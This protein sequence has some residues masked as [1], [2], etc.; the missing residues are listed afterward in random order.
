[1]RIGRRAAALA[2]LLAMAGTATAGAQ[3]PNHEVEHVKVASFD[4]TTLDGWIVRPADVPA[5]AR[6]PVVLW[7]APYFG[8][9]NFYPFPATL[10]YPKCTYA[11]G[12]NPELYDN[13][14]VSEAVPV[15][16][17]LEHG[18][19]VAIFNVRGTGN[20]GGCFDWFGAREQRDQ[21]ELVEWLGTRPWSNGNVGMMGLSYHGTT[22]WE[23]AIQNPP[24]LRTIVPA[25]IVSD[26][27]LFSH[28]PQGATFAT[29]GLFEGNFA[30]RVSLTPP[31]HGPAEHFTVDH[32]PVR[33]ERLCPEVAK[34]VAEDTAGTHTDLRDAAFWAERRLIDRF[35]EIEA[36]VFLV[37]GFQDHYLSGHQVQANEVWHTLR[38]PKRMLVGQWGHSF[39]EFG[40]YNPR[41]VVDDWHDRLLEWL[42][43]WLKDG[44]GPAPGEGVVEYQEGLYEDQASP[45]ASTIDAPAPPWH[46]SSAWPPAEARE[47][48]LHLAEGRLTGDPRAGDGS[49]EASPQIGALGSP[50]QLLCPEQGPR[51]GPTSVT[52]LSEPVRE[53]VRIAGNPFAHLRITSD[54]PGGLVAVHV[55]DV[56]PD[57]V[58]VADDG[59]AHGVRYWSAGTADLRFHAG[60][61]TGRDFPVGTPTTLRVDLTDL[62]ETLQPGH[63]LAVVV[64]RGDVLDR[65]GQPL[66]PQVRVHAGADAEASHVVLPVVCGTLGG[67]APVVDHPRRPFLPPSARS[68]AG[69]GAQGPPVAC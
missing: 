41:W 29:I 35:D 7:S 54:L 61:M 14:S 58:C 23:A 44:E 52:Y 68:R 62:A 6:L 32:V 25:G 5:G 66:Y 69:G 64:S 17:L 21:Y 10:P 22:P 45:L 39:P 57:F 31:L 2:V 27:Y 16:L 26:A 30:A 67:S 42:D 55:F 11:T 20:S 18:Y 28:T 50:K 9:C 65:N 36:S 24:H 49:F 33:A 60:N 53:P 1:M 15:D 59:L 43:H 12:D 46:R 34:F 38:S 8:Q 13:S 40:T 51:G 63:R 47:E 4:G 19:A 37:D 3:A 48:T 56:A